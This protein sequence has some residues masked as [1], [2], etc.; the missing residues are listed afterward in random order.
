MLKKELQEKEEAAKLAKQPAA[1]PTPE[2]KPEEDSDIAALRKSIAARRGELSKQ[3][4][5]DKYMA[6]LAAGLGILGGTSP[7]AFTNIGQGALQGVALSSQLA[8][9]RREEEQDLLA[10][11]LG[12]SRAT[13]YEKMRVDQLKSNKEIAAAKNAISQQLADI[14]K[15]QGYRDAADMWLNSPNRTALEADLK[16]RYGKNW[17]QDGKADLELSMARTKF[18]QELLSGGGLFGGNVQ[19]ASALLAR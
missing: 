5:Q 6:L 1:A 18:I 16:K 12:L 15:Q 19:Q 13:L 17:K 9:Q 10:A 3:R 11:R 8:K 2:V 7:Y 4:E 14:K